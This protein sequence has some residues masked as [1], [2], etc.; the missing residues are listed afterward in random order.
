M[1]ERVQV[2]RE[3]IDQIVFGMENQD[4][5]FYLDTL[6]SRV[7]SD[8][9]REENDRDRYIEV[10]QWRSVDGYN[11]M[12]Q[13]AATLH[14]PIYRERL[15]SILASGRGVFRQFKDTVRERHEIERAWFGFKERHM[16]GLVSDWINELREQ[17]GLERLTNTVLET[18]TDELVTI[19]FEFRDVTPAE[20][21]ELHA[22]DRDAFW[23]L[24][25]DL[26][27]SAVELLYDEQRA[28]LAGMDSETS[29]VRVVDTQGGEFAGF[30]WAHVVIK[31]EQKIAFVR[32]LY[33][34]PEFRGLG[35]A[36]Q[37]L[38]WF[39]EA[40]HGESIDYVMLDLQGE[41]LALLPHF[42]DYGMKASRTA[43]TLAVEP[44]YRSEHLV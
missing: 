30:I 17:E 44:W 24:Y 16:R 1:I 18:T 2:S 3:L 35:I 25:P 26:P 40:A 21:E 20:V 15:R 7:V 43:L 12:E 13:F 22:L 19:D 11:L 29:R 41:A 4:A 8:D 14:N 42:S 37:L 31:D 36:R 9:D 32:Q 34:L 23:E 5:T 28:R 33:V 27:D 10:P 6:E 39:F 38:F